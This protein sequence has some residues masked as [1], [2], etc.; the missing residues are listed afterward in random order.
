[1][2]KL[3]SQCS[4]YED[5][6]HFTFA[7]QF[8][9]DNGREMAASVPLAAF[10]NDNPNTGQCELYIQNV[11]GLSETEVILGGMFM[12]QFVG[13]Y[14]TDQKYPDYSVYL[15]LFVSESNGMTTAY[16]ANIGFPDDLPSPF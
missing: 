14:H 9:Q 6:W 4:D 5:L 2:C 8:L 16:V 7:I 10:A 3:S 13:Y 12:S 11:E 1:M 15:D